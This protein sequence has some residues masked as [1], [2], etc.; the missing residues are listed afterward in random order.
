[1]SQKNCAKLF[2]SELRQ[3]STN[4][5]NFWQK[6]DKEAEM[7]KM[8]SFSTSSNSHDHTTVLNAD[9]RNC[10]TTLKV[11]ICSKL[12]DNLN[13]TNKV[14]CGLFTRIISLYNSSVQ[15]CQNLCPKWAPRVVKRL[16]DDA[17]ENVKP[18]LQLHVSC[19]VVAYAASR[20]YVTVQG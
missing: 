14:K 17:T 20:E 2:L 3:I 1:M 4:L 18:H 13:S 6:D 8:Y 7:C 9:V 10:Y 15:N 11:V 16:D 5:D 19:G 12:S